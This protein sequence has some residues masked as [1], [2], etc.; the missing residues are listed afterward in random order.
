MLFFF[1]DSSSTSTTVCDHCRSR[2]TPQLKLPSGQR[3]L[4]DLEWF[5]QKSVLHTITIIGQ[6]SSS[7]GDR[8]RKTCLHLLIR[9]S[10]AS[11]SVIA[12]DASGFLIIHKL[13]CQQTSAIIPIIVFGKD[14][15]EANTTWFMFAIGPLSDMHVMMK[16]YRFKTRRVSLD[17]QC[18]CS[19][20]SKTK[21]HLIAQRWLS[22]IILVIRITPP[23]SST[24]KRELTWTC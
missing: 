20:S 7:I 24:G 17:A 4:R 6:S 13:I 16:I 5:L 21:V 18:K 3:F 23:P 8:T 1:S 22:Q 12:R 15:Y 10:A 19:K 2:R 11:T 9:H 14:T